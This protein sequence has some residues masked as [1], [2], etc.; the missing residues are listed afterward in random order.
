MSILLKSIL[1]VGIPVILTAASIVAVRHRL[2][3][4]MAVKEKPH[5]SAPI[6]IAMGDS[7]TFGDGV[8]GTRSTDS[9][10]VKLETQL[11]G[12]YQV[13]NYGVSGATLQDEGD[14]PYWN[15]PDA[16]LQN[17]VQSALSLNPEI[18]IL[19]LGSND[20]KPINWDVN[21]YVWEL[22]ARVKE[23][24]ETASIKHLILMSPPCAFPYDESGVVL[25]EIRNEILRDEIR[26]IVEQVA[27]DNDVDFL[28]LYA[29]TENHPEYFMDGV[30]PNSF[31]NMAI[32]KHISEFISQF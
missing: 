27:K 32:A 28:D 26:P 8:I 29:F 30:H 14:K 5:S 18:V 19:M 23:L 10:P 2:N 13:L 4:Y 7:I 25:Y 12:N 16:A 21:R 15:L 20:T 1:K 3:P 22:D 24:K 9:W 6:I 11:A 17:Y 31:G